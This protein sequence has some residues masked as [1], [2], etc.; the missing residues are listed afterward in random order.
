MQLPPS[1]PAR[2]DIEVQPTPELVPGRAPRPLSLTVSSKAPLTATCTRQ[3]VAPACRDTLVIASAAIRNAATSTAAAGAA[4]SRVRPPRRRGRSPGSATRPAAG[5][6]RSGPPRR[7]RADAGRR[8]AAAPP[9]SRTWP[10]RGSG[11]AA[12]HE[13]TRRFRLWAAFSLSTIA[14]RLGPRPSCRSRR[15][16]RRSSSRAVTSRALDAWRSAASVAA[17]TT[18]AACRA[19]SCSRATSAV[20]RV[21]PARDLDREVT[22]SLASVH[23]R[24]A[25]DA[26]LVAC[27]RRPSRA[28]PRLGRP[29]V[30]RR[31]SR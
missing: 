13:P 27:R 28:R 20:E 23:E 9:R 19:R 6:R 3:C 15:S 25:Y 1:S 22:Q 7:W 11:A 4:G 10:P 5:S 18:T 12:R 26:V 8:P 16:R 17:W 24:D 21:L 31:P 30:R 2:S 14:A 29:G